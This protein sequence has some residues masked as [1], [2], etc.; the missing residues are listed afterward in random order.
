MTITE[1]KA[2]EV[3]GFNYTAGWSL[4]KDALGDLD[5]K[6]LKVTNHRDRQGLRAGRDQ[7]LEGHRG[8]RPRRLHDE[9]IDVGTTVSP[10]CLSTD[11]LPKKF[12]KITINDTF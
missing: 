4:G 2:F 3:D 12:D 6:G 8:C 10:S 11:A 1:G 9:P 7:A 5:V